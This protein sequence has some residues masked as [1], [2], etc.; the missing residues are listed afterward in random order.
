MVRTIRFQERLKLPSKKVYT[1]AKKSIYFSQE[2]YILFFFF[3]KG[4]LCLSYNIYIM[5]GNH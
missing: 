5:L 1:F 2:N 3:S 4:Y